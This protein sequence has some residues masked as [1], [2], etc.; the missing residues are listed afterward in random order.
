LSKDLD[1]INCVEFQPSQ[2]SLHAKVSANSFPFIRDDDFPTPFAE[3]HISQPH[4][5][6]LILV[7]K[8]QVVVGRQ[9]YNYL[10][11]FLSLKLRD[12]SID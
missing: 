8:V 7:L 6:N 5:G 9:D 12:M 3:F 11:L 1:F 2:L 10:G 4:R